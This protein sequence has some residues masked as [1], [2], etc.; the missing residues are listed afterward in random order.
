MAFG[1]VAILIGAR[2]LEV[3][4]HVLAGQTH[5]ALLERAPE[6]VVDHRIDERAVAHPEPFA[7]P[8]QQIRRAAHRLH[9]A[10]DRNVD[11]ARRDALRG[12]HHG[13]QARP[14]HLVD[15]HRRHVVLQP[16]VERRL[17]CRILSF[18]R[19]DH[20]AH[21]AFVDGARLDT[22]AAD[23][24]AHGDGAELRRREI[25]QRAEKLARRRANG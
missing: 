6:A 25:L 2:D 11:V 24:L 8:W 15:G 23:G 4:G 13:L 14:A 21:D 18:A 17:S 10:G 3:L 12:E 16:A 7:H 20:V 9:A 1:R 5:V 22:G 19:R